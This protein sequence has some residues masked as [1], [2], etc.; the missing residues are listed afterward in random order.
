MTAFLNFCCPI[1]TSCGLCWFLSYFS[2]CFFACSSFT[3]CWSGWCLVRGFFHVCGGFG[4]GACWILV[5]MLGGWSFWRRLVTFGLLRWCVHRLHVIQS[6]SS[7]DICLRIVIIW[8]C[9][10]AS[11]CQTRGR[12]SLAAFGWLRHSIIGSGSFCLRRAWCCLLNLLNLNVNLWTLY[13]LLS[14]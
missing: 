2:R 9:L 8:A 13:L 4:L 1:L 10:G 11:Y 12:T 3:S 7:V 14:D 6:P 5:W